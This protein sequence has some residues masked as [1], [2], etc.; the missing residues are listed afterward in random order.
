MIFLGREISYP[1]AAEVALKFNEISYIF[2]LAYPTGELKHG[3]LA[4]L[5]QSTTVMLFSH[6]DQQIYQK[7]L[8]A[9]QEVRARVESLVVCAYEGQHEL[10][11]LG[12]MVFLLP[13]SSDTLLGPMVAIGV[14]QYLICMTADQ[15][16]RPIDKPRHLAKSVTVE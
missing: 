9:A 4:L 7:I 13:R 15:L 11:A 3:P 16:K 10:I 6:Q 5:D 8:I 1:L 14:L 12:T 2:S